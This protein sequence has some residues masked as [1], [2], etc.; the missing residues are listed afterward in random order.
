MTQ[1]SDLG[2]V[3][4]LQK[5]VRDAGYVHPT[6][7]QVQAIPDVLAGRDLLGC[8][9]TGTGKTA[10]FA[11][12]I[13]QRLA[14][15]G[16]PP[17]TGARRARA[18]RNARAP[19]ALV[20][21][22]TREL[23]A[24]IAESFATYG[25]GLP[26]DTTVI[27]GGVSQNPQVRALQRG[28]DVLV[29]TPGRLVDLM[30][31][32]HA[33]LD[34]I[35]VLVLDEADHMLDLGFLPDVRRILAA[36][37][38]RRQTLLFSA[39]MPPPIAKLAAAVL[40]DPVEVFVTPAAT[41]AEE[42]EQ[43]V[44]HV[45]R[46]NKPALLASLLEDPAVERALVFTRTKRGADKVARLLNREGIP[47]HAIHGNKSQGQRERTLGG[48]R[49][50]RV[51]VLV[52]TDIAARGIDVDGI[53]HVVNYELPNVPETYV[54][55][56][57]RTARAGASGIAI[58]LCSGEERELLRDVEKLIRRT[59]AAIGAP[60]HDRAEPARTRGKSGGRARGGQAGSGARD[61]RRE[62]VRS[63]GPRR[64]GGDS[65]RRPGAGGRGRGGSRGGA[66]L[67]GARPASAP[68]TARS[69]PGETSFGAGL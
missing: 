13:L 45:E 26:L 17:E 46:A 58:S 67:V 7:I 36:I 21:A 12:P 42:V 3:A 51:R 28:V 6:P 64:A 57:G 9:R 34:A 55:R 43:R 38:K 37:P 65:S 63:G 47:A 27:Y 48:F 62:R 35:E 68:S 52:A 44:H 49:T 22:P 25:A 59:I 66:A 5:A 31:Q 69:S 54:H 2:L 10:A 53:T 61:T 41:P 60:V 39:T 33:R 23:A 24:Q 40:H 56:I 4:P 32:R 50:G 8:A 1:F 15:G 18:A 29:A 20:L 14:A 11:L 19:R 30:G 16:S